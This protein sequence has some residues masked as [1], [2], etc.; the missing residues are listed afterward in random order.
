M[1]MAQLAR[2]EVY[3]KYSHDLIRFATGLAGPDDGPD[4]VSAAMLSVL[5]SQ[6]W[7]QVQ[8]PRA[9]LYRAVLNEARKSYKTAM[10]RAGAEARAAV[11]AGGTPARDVEPEILEAV[12][13][14]SVRQRAVVFLAYW[15]DLRPAEIARRLDLSESTVHRYL[16]RAESRLRRLLHDR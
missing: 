1:D 7:D 14:L 15:E 2:S 3:E 4:L 6:S 8:N 16:S 12:G 9:Y 11:P 13:S 5:W 10:R